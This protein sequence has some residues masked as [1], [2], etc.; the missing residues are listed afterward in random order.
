ML[1]ASVNGSDCTG[2]ATAVPSRTRDVTAAAA[3][4]DTQGSSVRM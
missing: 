1:L 3:L 2:N 4:S